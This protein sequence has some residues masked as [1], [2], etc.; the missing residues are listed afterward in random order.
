MLGYR[1]VYFAKCRAIVCNN[2]VDCGGWLTPEFSIW[3]FTKT[4][5]MIEVVP[6]ILKEEKCKLSLDSS[7][8]VP[9]LNEI[10]ASFSCMKQIRGNVL[11]TK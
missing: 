9:C 2:S 11:P 7:F 6:S 3:R 1:T 8:Q 4:G 5:T 10:N